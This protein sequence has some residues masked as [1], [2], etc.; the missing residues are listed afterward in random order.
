[1]VKG[2]ISPQMPSLSGKGKLEAIYQKVQELE[3]RS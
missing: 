2:K 3:A 1:M